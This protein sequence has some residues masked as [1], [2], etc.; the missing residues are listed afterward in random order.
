MAQKRK[1]ITI[2]LAFQ[3]VERKTALIKESE[4]G[5]INQW[6]NQTSQMSRFLT[7]K[8]RT[9]SWKIEILVL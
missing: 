2:Q 7:L 6:S 5:L 8:Q 3:I 1:K 9:E 4:A